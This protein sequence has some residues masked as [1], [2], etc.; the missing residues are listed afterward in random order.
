MSQVPLFHYFYFAI[1][2]SRHRPKQFPKPGSSETPNLKSLAFRTVLTDCLIQEIRFR[3]RRHTHKFQTKPREKKRKP[4]ADF[5][6]ADW[7]R[8]ESSIWPHPPNPQRGETNP[9]LRIL[10]PRLG[11]SGARRHSSPCSPASP[12]RI[13]GRALFPQYRKV[14]SNRSL[15]NIPT[16]PS[17][18]P[19]VNP[20]E[21]NEA[22][23]RPLRRSRGCHNPCRC[24]LDTTL[25]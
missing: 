4:G 14:A 24:R 1:K 25:G 15:Y 8:G 17:S 19:T 23:G 7:A 11:D 22:S 18:Y 20:R 9:R 12:L 3:R 6:P 13:P 10:A 16:S 21:R 5:R 2:N